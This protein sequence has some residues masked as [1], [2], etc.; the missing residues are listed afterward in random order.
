MIYLLRK[1]GKAGYIPHTHYNTLFIEAKAWY[2][3]E[4]NN[5]FLGNKPNIIPG[6]SKET[7]T[8]RTLGEKFTAF[9]EIANVR[10]GDRR[11]ELM[12]N[13]EIKCAAVSFSV[14]TYVY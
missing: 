11:R 9:I 8:R 3:G 2:L 6:V 10:D 4:K 13:E 7:S 5:L 1:D 12:V 14:L